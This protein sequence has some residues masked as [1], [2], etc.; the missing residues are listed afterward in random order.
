MSDNLIDV[1]YDL[2]L[3]DVGLLRGELGTLPT[4][5]LNADVEQAISRARAL[6]G[7]DSPN[8]QAR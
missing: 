7:A 8:Q 4:G 6:L 3:K 5:S 1:Q 2:L